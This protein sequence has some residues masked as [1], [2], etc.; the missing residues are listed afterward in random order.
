MNSNTYVVVSP[1]QAQR[2]IDTL[3][4]DQERGNRA[5]KLVLIVQHFIKKNNSIA[6]SKWSTFEHLFSVLPNLIEV[7]LT[8]MRS[9]WPGGER[10]ARVL[11]TLT[12]LRV[13][14]LS[15]F[16]PTTHELDY[17]EFVESRA[18]SSSRRMT[19]LQ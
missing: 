11:S 15:N 16:H 17:V 10:V 3:R 13:V 8:F 19:R 6:W 7:D 1:V 4:L 5:S 2:L 12:A 14:N 9:R 18:S